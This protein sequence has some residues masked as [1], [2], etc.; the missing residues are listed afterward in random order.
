MK[1]KF[2]ISLLIISLL[3][4]IFINNIKAVSTLDD[5][6]SGAKDF[7]EQGNSGSNGTDYAG[8][9]DSLV[10]I[11]NAFLTIGTIVATIV[12]AIMG[13]L[14]MTSTSEEKAKI[15]ESLM[16]FVI[17]CIVMFGAFTIWKVVVNMGALLE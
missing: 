11:F 3:S 13:I 15:K 16:P 12:L 14:F 6:I 1:K 8:F 9:N 10:V 17:G 7:I 2:L 5:M 4:V